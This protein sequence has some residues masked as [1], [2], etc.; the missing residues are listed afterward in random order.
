MLFCHLLSNILDPDKTQNFVGPDLGPNCLQNEHRVKSILV[1][2]IHGLSK[3]VILHCVH[4]KYL[5]LKLCILSTHLH[6][7]C[8]KNVQ[9]TI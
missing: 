2:I 9:F 7:T 4:M 3:I 5:Y 8:I 1:D 6:C